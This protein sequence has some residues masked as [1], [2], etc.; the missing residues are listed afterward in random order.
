MQRVS[1]QHFMSI[2]ELNREPR[3]FEYLHLL[4]VGAH[5]QVVIIL[6]SSLYFHN[7]RGKRS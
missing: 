5:W 4:V 7:V 2:D 1:A 6:L 3:E